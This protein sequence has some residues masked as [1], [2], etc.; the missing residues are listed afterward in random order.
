MSATRAPG[1]PRVPLED[2][3]WSRVEKS[4]G[5]WIW[6]GPVTGSGYGGIG[7][8]G[9]DGAFL[10]AHVVSYRLHYGEVPPGLCVL[11]HCDV[12]LSVRPD[13]L[14]AG[15]HSDNAVDR[16]AKGRRNAPR[17][18]ANSQCRLREAEVEEIRA[19][20]DTQAVLAAR[21]HVSQSLISRIRSGDR[22]ARKASE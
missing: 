9:A 11:H 8:G 22:R 15:T 19:S 10:S 3:F 7:E 21:Y 1:R 5:C 14:F 4:D 6:T 16:E 13:H 17:G 12:P 2:R 18:E 20:H